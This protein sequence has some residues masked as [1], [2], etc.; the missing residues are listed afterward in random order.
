VIEGTI[1]DQLAKTIKYVKPIQY[2]SARGLTAEVYQQIQAEF[3]PVPPLTLHSPVPKVMAGVWSI[4]RETFWAGSVARAL[5]EAVAAAVS[6]TNEC[7]YC[8]DVH[9][10]MLHATGDHDMASA[11]RQGDPG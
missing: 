3:L 1:R 9:T 6:K 8:I 4:L 2:I 11:I 7:P 5:K 10:S